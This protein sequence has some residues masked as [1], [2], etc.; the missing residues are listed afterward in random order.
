MEITLL[1]IAVIGRIVMVRQQ[2]MAW[3]VIVVFILAFVNFAVLLSFQRA[4]VAFA[5]FGVFGFGGLA[6]L[7]FRKKAAPE[8]VDIDE[9]DKAIAKTAALGAAMM[10]Y[11]AFIL[12]CMLTWEFCRHQGKE[13]VS[14]HVLP[15]I[16]G[17]GGMV[18]FV[19]WAITIVVLYGR[20]RTD[21]EN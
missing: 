18:F 12:T 15:T 5:G 7:L 20:E 8:E 14:I 11:G 3:F 19:T 6:P 13:V 1:G 17:I 10:S 16:V 2:K 9:R 21:G 4:Q